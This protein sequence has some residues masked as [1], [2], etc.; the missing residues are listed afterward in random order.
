MSR[1]AKR[2]AYFSA[3]CFLIAFAVS[4]LSHKGIA[5]GKKPI[6]APVWGAQIFDYGNLAGMESGHV[7]SGSNDSNVRVTVQKSSTGG[8]VTSSTVHFFIYANPQQTYAT[9]HDVVFPQEDLILGD[10]GPVGYCGF[11]G[12]PVSDPCLID[13]V[14]TWHPKPGYVHLLFY[15]AIGADLESTDAFPLDVPIQWTGTG[16]V[17]VYFWNAFDPIMAGDAE[18][19]ESV[20]ASLKNLCIEN[21]KGIWITRTGSDTWDIEIRQQVFDW[22]QFY[23]YGTT[24]IGRNGRTYTTI[25][26]YQPLAAKGELT[27]KMKLIKNPS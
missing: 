18:P 13:F 21:G 11:P 12:P 19:F 2:L 6:P 23:S 8:V 17:T 25:T 10:A 3:F 14:N 24:S 27:Y 1:E 7:Y 22:S 26:N 20:T 16:A 4:V 15:F 9:F 5:A